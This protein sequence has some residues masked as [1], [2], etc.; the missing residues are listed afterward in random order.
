MIAEN[1]I[2]SIVDEPPAESNEAECLDMGVAVA[3]FVR[4][5]ENESENQIMKIPIRSKLS[6]DQY[7]GSLYVVIRGVSSFLKAL[8]N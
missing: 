8:H 2:F 3:S 7:I 4:W 5:V 1:I 6:P